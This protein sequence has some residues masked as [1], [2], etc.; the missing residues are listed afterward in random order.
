MPETLLVTFFSDT[1][2]TLYSLYVLTATRQWLGNAVS[3]CQLP[4][5]ALCSHRVSGQDES[6]REPGHC[7]HKMWRQCDVAGSYATTI[8]FRFKIRTW[9]LFVV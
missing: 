7:H 4:Y 6:C 9:Y 1:V 3:C 5:I 2:Y 8:S